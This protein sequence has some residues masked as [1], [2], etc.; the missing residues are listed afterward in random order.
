MPSLPVSATAQR[1]LRGPRSKAAKLAAA[2]EGPG[3]RF[4]RLEARDLRKALEGHARLRGLAVPEAM[5]VQANVPKDTA[6][7]RIQ[8]LIKA[9]DDVKGLLKVFLDYPY[10]M[11]ASN[12]ST[13][14][15]RIAKVA[16]AEDHAK[17]PRLSKELQPGLERLVKL[18]T[19]RAPS[20][21]SNHFA[22]VC[23]AVAKLGGH[24]K[25]RAH[26]AAAPGLFAA[27]SLHAPLKI[28]NFKAQELANTVWA[29]AKEGT[30]AEDFYNAV[31]DESVLKISKFNHQDLANTAWAFASAKVS[32]PE[33][34]E[35]VAAECVKKVETFNPHD[36]ELANIVWA[37]AKA[38]IQAPALFE[39]VAAEALEEIEAFNAQDLA[40]TVWAYAT[41]RVEAPKLFQAVALE[42][43]KKMEASSSSDFSNMVWAFSK[44]GSEA[45]GLFEA[46]ASVAVKKMTS[47]NAQNLAN[48]SWA[49]ANSEIKSPQLFEAVS[50]EAVA[51]IGSFELREMATIVWASA[52]VMHSTEA[53]AFP[54]YR[55]ETAQLLA[56]E[57]LESKE[58][59]KECT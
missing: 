46:V 6:E 38:G 39:A 18:A 9:C 19:S 37:F 12:I 14:L 59:T 15:Q 22:N 2:K 32:A 55:P 30:V 31:G 49:Y 16:R 23:W 36:H 33:L 56:N 26:I 7:Y 25:S 24:A 27:V 52:T 58:G 48:M 8:T 50:I 53:T 44:M 51:K 45:P 20:L 5:R 57:K 28:S 13:C 29:F 42:A 35:A 10:D 21:Q 43:S 3:K 1:V 11:E 17:T 47:F 34:F 41:A 54:D 4:R 40:N